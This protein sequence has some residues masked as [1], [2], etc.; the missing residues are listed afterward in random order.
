MFAHRAQDLNSSHRRWLQEMQMRI[1]RL[2]TLTPEKPKFTYLVQSSPECSSP[3]LPADE[4]MFES[5][6]NGLFV[7]NLDNTKPN[8]DLQVM[9]F[10]HF[11]Q[12]GQV[13]SVRVSKDTCNRPYALVHFSQPGVTDVI[14][15]QID[16]PISNQTALTLNGRHLRIEK[17]RSN[18]TLFIKH[19]PAEMTEKQ[20]YSILVLAGPLVGFNMLTP[21]LTGSSCSTALAAFSSRSSALAAA[22]QLKQYTEWEL[23]IKQEIIPNKEDDFSNNSIYIAKLNYGLVTPSLLRSRF[24]NYG[25]VDQILLNIYPFQKIATAYVKFVSEGSCHWAVQKEHDAAWLGSIIRVE[26]KKN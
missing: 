2:E 24:S 12:F 14:L 15:G 13:S 6:E 3:E 8:V 1:A 20:V 4:K 11:A 26:I 25:P 9:V 18:C 22:N 17:S 5:Q 16:G 21:A 23:S 10:N 7:G 19:I